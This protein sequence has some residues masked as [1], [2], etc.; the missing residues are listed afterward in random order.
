MS[1][2]F[3]K[4]IVVFRGLSRNYRHLKLAALTSPGIFAQS[5]DLL[6]NEKLDRLQPN[7]S[8]VQPGSEWRL[9]NEED[10]PLLL[11]V[12]A[13]P[14]ALAGDEKVIAVL[15]D[16]RDDQL[17][18]FNG[19]ISK[20][21]A[22]PGGQVEFLVSR[23]GSGTV[24]RPFDFE[25]VFDAGRASI[26]LTFSEG[27]LIAPSDEFGL[28]LEAVY[29]LPEDDW[30]RIGVKISPDGRTWSMTVSNPDS[31]EEEFRLDELQ[32]FFGIPSLEVNAD[33]GV[34][35]FHDIRLLVPA[36]ADSS[37]QS[38]DATYLIGEIQVG[39]VSP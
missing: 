21:S 13:N 4:K 27:G 1:N 18:V 37:G 12:T 6:F 3:C 36:P 32:I 7:L 17:E 23:N 35:T 22:K 26:R 5:I 25:V 15:A 39:L 29:K 33:T 8:L 31:G 19:L 2:I 30:R 28:P 16:E 38:L 11:Q 24:Q 9:I 34:S 20:A 10:N 14:N